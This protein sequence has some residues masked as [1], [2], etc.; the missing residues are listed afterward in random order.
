MPRGVVTGLK[1]D[2]HLGGAISGTGLHAPPRDPTLV[3]SGASKSRP[4]AGHPHPWRILRRHF[5][6]PCYARDFNLTSASAAG[7]PSHR[8]SKS[9]VCTIVFAWP[10]ADT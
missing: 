2:G 4:E 3:R 7:A 5:A 1:G 8:L 10:G 6:T 9:S